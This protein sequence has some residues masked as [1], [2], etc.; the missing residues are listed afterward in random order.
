[1]SVSTIPASSRQT[2]THKEAIDRRFS[3][4]P[5][6][7]RQ[8]RLSLAHGLLVKSEFTFN[9]NG[10]NLQ[11]RYCPECNVYRP[12]RT[13][14]C[15]I[16]LQCVERFDHH[17]P[18]I[19]VC[20][21]KKNYFWFI[22]YLCSMVLLL[23]YIAFLCSYCIGRE[24]TRWSSSP[25][26]G[27]AVA[28]F[29]LLGLAGVAS[30]SF[31]CFVLPLTVYHLYLIYTNQTTKEYVKRFSENHPDNPFSTTLVKTLKKFCTSRT[32]RSLLPRKVVQMRDLRGQ[33]HGD[34]DQTALSKPKAYDY[35]FPKLA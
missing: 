3:Q 11:C 6:R 34:A 12:P 24:A 15:F 22:I 16:C 25:T 1:M 17:C 30:I 8:A 35:S 33:R 14:H 13:S 4:I 10:Y 26:H 29:I 9:I 23:L 28:I 5:F 18:W 19:G 21:G 32:K 31:A 27:L 7:D 20:I 2:S